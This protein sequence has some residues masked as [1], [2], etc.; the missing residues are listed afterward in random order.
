M[1]NTCDISEQTRAPWKT[2]EKST[3]AK[4]ALDQ[5][6]DVIYNVLCII[7]KSTGGPFRRLAG[8]DA[9]NR[10]KI[11]PWAATLEATKGN[12][13]HLYEGNLILPQRSRGGEA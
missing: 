8:V 4:F 1:G 2:P 5:V 11:W 12:K 10:N 6:F 9:M 7:R 13:S 3:F